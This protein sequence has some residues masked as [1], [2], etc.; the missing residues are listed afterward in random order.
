MSMRNKVSFSSVKSST[1]AVL[2]VI[3]VFL[4]LFPF[5]NSMNQ[6]LVKII[7]PALF[8][9]PLQ[10]R[11]IP[12]EVTLVRVILSFLRVPMTQGAPGAIA[13]TIIGNRE[14]EIPV[15]IAWNC[16]GWQSLLVILSTLAAGLFGKF[17]LASKIEALIIGV[18]GTFWLNIMRIS[19][20]FFLFY[21]INGPFAMAFHDY[22]GPL[23]TI[24]WV[25]I[26]WFYTFNLV[27]VPQK[28]DNR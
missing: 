19:L 12:Y 28:L 2:L 22:A 1:R 13:I 27:L 25:F 4:M 18:L 6:L 9:K 14:G 24:A 20:I 7:E 5:I 23:I 21:H 11:L 17:T 26:F 16:I 8:V 3:V 10:D 15:V